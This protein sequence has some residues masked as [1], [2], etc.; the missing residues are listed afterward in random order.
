MIIEFVTHDPIANRDSTILKNVN[1]LSIAP[2]QIHQAAGG[3][4]ATST[5][6]ANK[7]LP[8]IGTFL[9]SQLQEEYESKQEKIHGL[10]ALVAL[11]KLK[12]QIIAYAKGLWPFN[13][14]SINRDNVAKYWQDLRDHESADVLA[15]S[16]NALTS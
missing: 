13:Q 1:P 15:V 7:T 2:I 5:A 8:R 3:L 11:E 12:D 4:S 14:A 16:H 10:E 6:D 9:V